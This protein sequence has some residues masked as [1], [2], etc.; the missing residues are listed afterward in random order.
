MTEQF[1][2]GIIND[3]PQDA[4][5]FAMDIGAYEGQYTKLLAKKFKYVYAVEPARYNAAV[6]DM[7][8]KYDFPDY[9]GNVRLLNKAV[10]D[11]EGLTKLY[12]CGNN[13][14]GHTINEDVVRTGKFSHEIDNFAYVKCTT[15]DT[16]AGGFPVDFIK[17]DIEGAEDFAW[18]GALN[19]LQFSP[20]LK[21]VLETHQTINGQR[22]YYFFREFG[23]TIYPDDGILRTDTHYLIEKRPK[24]D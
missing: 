1:V 8:L 22:L 5:Y 4:G 13:P 7:I 23:F 24:V 14:G 3:L 11:H 18:N 9:D 6:I 20:N 16:L 17:M 10:S 12:L 21:I 15:I 2:L 19:T